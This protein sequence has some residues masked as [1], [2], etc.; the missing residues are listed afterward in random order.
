MQAA[1][2]SQASGADLARAPSLWQDRASLYML[3]FGALLHL[4]LASAIHLSPDEAHYA[5]YAAHLDWSYYDHPPLVGWLQWPWLQL[6]GSDL[7][8][9]LMPMLA[10]CVAALGLRALTLDC[11]PATAG[12]RLSPHHAALGLWL[13]SPL[14]HLLG[15][16]WVPDTALL[17][18]V[19]A[20]MALVWRLVRREGGARLGL[21]AALGLCMGLS[22]LAKYTTVV[23][24]LGALLVLHWGR[25]LGLWR[26]PGF[27]LALLLAVAVV[28]PVFW[29]NAT[30]DWISLRYQVDHAA[31]SEAP[32]QAWRVLWFALVQVLVYGLLPVFGCWWAC[33]SPRAVGLDARVLC[34]GFGLPVLLLLAW[35][36]A[37]RLPLPHWAA[38]AWLALLP[39]AGAGVARMYEVGRRRVLGLAAWQALGVVAMVLALLWGGGPAESGEAAQTLPHEGGRGVGNPV[40]DLYGWDEASARAKALAAERRVARLAVHNWTLASRVAWY[41]RPLPVQVLDGR[42]GQFGLWFGEMPAGAD[43]LVLDWSLMSRPMPVGPEGFERCDLLESRPVVHLGR[44]L[45]HFSFLHC[46]GWRSVPAAPAAAPGSAPGTLP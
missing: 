13:L 37:R 10:W 34:L 21:W 46:R 27:W 44:Q 42:P 38:P 1:A 5:L 16:A 25:G 11:L 39:L 28:T 32:R 36:S 20:M 9:R 41:A 23:L 15:V 8:L 35:L 26:Q 33:R 31:G 7:L 45:S 40:A 18:L 12:Q 3:A 22:G 2:A 17:M 30:H 6:G 4:A 14:P 43:A 19:P 29:W 24:G